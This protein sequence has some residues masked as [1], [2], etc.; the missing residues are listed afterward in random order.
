MSN[1]S[2]KL[3]YREGTWG[4]WCGDTLVREL[5]Q[6]DLL[7][8]VLIICNMPTD[9]R[10]CPVYTYILRDDDEDTIRESLNEVAGDML[11]EKDLGYESYD[12]L[13]EVKK[14]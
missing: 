5:S 6:N 3:T 1:L 11:E 8:A 7:D 2:F 12:E 9:E 10:G 13:K 4:L 14:I